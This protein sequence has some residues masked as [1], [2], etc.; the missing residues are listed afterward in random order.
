LAEGGIVSS[1]YERVNKH[2]GYRFV[3]STQERAK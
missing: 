2:S 1:P 3:V